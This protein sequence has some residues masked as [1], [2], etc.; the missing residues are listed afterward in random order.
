MDILDRRYHRGRS[1]A[2]GEFPPCYAADRE[3]VGSGSSVP[4][5][6]STSRL[7]EL[8]Q[9]LSVNT[10]SIAQ[11][12]DALKM[13]NFILSKQLKETKKQLSEANIVIDN[14]KQHV[15]KMGGEA[16]FSQG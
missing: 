1:L 5:Y 8:A 2:I 7:Q 10:M 9:E 15:A 13:R 6:E 14:L 3:R 4:K 16:C 11:E 12:Y